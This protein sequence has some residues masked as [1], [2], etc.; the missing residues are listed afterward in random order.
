MIGFD[1]SCYVILIFRG[2]ATHD[3]L[4]FPC[5]LPFHHS[6][7]LAVEFFQTSDLD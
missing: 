7:D 5:S 6:T 4:P 1:V 2:F 3:A